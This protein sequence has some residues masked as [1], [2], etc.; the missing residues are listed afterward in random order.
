MSDSTIMAI[1]SATANAINKQENRIER[2]KRKRRSRVFDKTENSVS[3]NT[4][5]IE[6]RDANASNGNTILEEM[7]KP[8]WILGSNESQRFK[9]RYQPE[10][11][12]IHRHTY[13]LSIVDG[14]GITYDINVHGVADIPRLDMNPNVIFSKV[15]T[16]CRYAHRN[17]T[18]NY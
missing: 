6:S 17:T 14:D 18:I 16:F 10:E 1:D 2:T 4:S 13:A 3:L 12:G 5:T 7:L 8:R 9:I 15:T 11:V